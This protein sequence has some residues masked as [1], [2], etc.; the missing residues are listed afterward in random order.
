MRQLFLFLF[1]ALTAVLCTPLSAQKAQPSPVCVF[2]P[3]AENVKGA[4]QAW[5]PGSVRDRLEAN[6]RTYT[7]FILIDRANESKIKTLQMKSE[8]ASYDEST[9]IE[10]GKLTSANCAVFST[11]RWTGKE[12]T[13][14]AG[15]TDLTTG[16]RKASAVSAARHGASALFSGAGCAVDE[17]TIALC[18][19]LGI[20]LSNSQVYVLQH[21]EASLSDSD[22]LAMSQK[23][24][25]AFQKQIAE[26]DKQ[27][28]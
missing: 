6:F 22:R 11:I 25:E 4:E 1:A 24:A 16:V 12:Y 13:L 9:I 19:Q 14:N 7:A 3:D 5:L 23:E 28:A 2:T 8:G 15:F 10:V 17:L 18:K 20:V 27:I 21:G 26:L